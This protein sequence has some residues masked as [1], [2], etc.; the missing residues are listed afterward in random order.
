M[1]GAG[2]DRPGSRAAKLT[3]IV[4]VILAA[5]LLADLAAAQVETPLDVLAVR[6]RAQGHVCD[7]PIKAE[8]DETASKPNRTVWRLECGNASYRIVLHPDG[9]AE[10]EAIE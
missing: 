6:V 10:I 1:A 2:T 8:K 5:G 9:A 3:P 4:P 7:K